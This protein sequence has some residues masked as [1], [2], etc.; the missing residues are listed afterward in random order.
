M[1]NIIIK[2]IPHT[3]RP[4][5]KALQYGIESLSNGE[6]LALILENGS[7]GINVLTLSQLLLQKFSNFRHIS[8]C[9]LG[10]LTKIKGI[11]KAKAIKI[12][13]CFEIARRFQEVN[14]QPG[15]ILQGS[16]QVF[17]HYH[18][19]LRDQKREKFFQFFSIQNIAL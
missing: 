1:Q 5:E 17:Y 4:R 3:E 15:I 14:I 9:S 6:L 8:N 16:K 13:A 10:E 2:E 7:K 11:G 18:E 19:K 12:K